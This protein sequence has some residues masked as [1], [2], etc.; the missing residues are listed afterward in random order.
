MLKNSQKLGNILKILILLL[1]GY[2]LSRA[3]PGVCDSEVVWFIFVPLIVMC[4]RAS[5]KQGFFYGMVFGEIFWLFNLYWLCELR[6]NGGPVVLVLLGLVGLTL[7]CSLYFGL[8]GYMISRLWAPLN[9]QISVRNSELLGMLDDED[10]RRYDALKRLYGRQFVIAELWRSV[11]AGVIW[12]ALEYIRAN[13]FTGF[14]WNLLG[15]SQFENLPIVQLSSMFGV[16]AISFVI[17]LVNM[18][19]ANVGMRIW[20]GIKNGGDG[21]VVRRHFDLILTLVLLMVC[22]LWGTLKVRS[23]HPGISKGA[24]HINICVV[25]PLAPCIFN[26]D[27][28]EEAEA[29]QKRLVELSALMC[30]TKADLVV[31][32]ETSLDF[33]MPNRDG[34]QYMNDLVNHFFNG[35]PILAGT[36]EIESTKEGEKIYNSSFFFD[37][38]A[39]ESIKTY[40]KRH[41]V[42]FGEYIPFDKTF[43]VLQRLSPSGVSCTPGEEVTLFKLGLYNFSTLICFED[44]ISHLARD[45]AKANAKFLI[46]QSNDSWFWNEEDDTEALQ[47]HANA[48]FRAVE[49]G[50]PMIRVSNKGYS[51]IIQPNGRV[52][53]KNMMIGAAFNQ[54]LKLEHTIFDFSPYTFYVRNGD[55]CFAI[56]CTVLT[57]CFMLYLVVK[58]FKKEG[59]DVKCKE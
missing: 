24:S 19:V 45:C 14:S 33:L 42:P 20:A 26:G 2:V 27:N 17:I 59:C 38:N 10:D 30:Y 12:V 15:V 47:H 9:E 5:A 50:L 18:A 16:Y 4:K 35:T 21:I 6:H 56:P 36:T 13:L 34:I 46:S 53:E 54:V 31:W 40:R 28:A 1:S 7:W 37:G 43:R 29:A 23:R 57:L 48:V 55:W 25:D 11:F 22:V 41:L 44:T 39:K 8:F 32:P 51:S 58:G 49:T 52:D 3:Y